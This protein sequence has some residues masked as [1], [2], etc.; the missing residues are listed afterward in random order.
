MTT[1]ALHRQFAPV[2]TPVEIGHVADARRSGVDGIEA[3]QALAPVLVV[4]VLPT[5]LIDVVA[6][7]RTPAVDCVDVMPPAVPLMVLP[8]TEAMM[9]APLPV[10]A[11]MPVATSTRCRVIRRNR[12]GYD[13]DTAS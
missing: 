12:R 11:L 8:A 1:P 2:T 10:L 4:T 13:R 3:E 6:V 9:T 7:L 5:V